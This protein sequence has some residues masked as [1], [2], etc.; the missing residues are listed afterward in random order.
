MVIKMCTTTPPALTHAVR[1][2]DATDDC[3]I[4]LTTSTTHMATNWTEFSTFFAEN[5]L[6]HCDSSF[7]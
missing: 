6:I 1:D 2:D 5:D 4:K 7:W 3:M